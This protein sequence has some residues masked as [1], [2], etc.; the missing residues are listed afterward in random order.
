MADVRYT[1]GYAKLT[2]EVVVLERI[3]SYGVSTRGPVHLTADQRCCYI[4]TSDLLRWGTGDLV[5]GE[6]S[7]ILDVVLTWLVTQAMHQVH[8]VQVWHQGTVW[9]RL[10]RYDRGEWHTWYRQQTEQK[11]EELWRKV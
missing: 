7:L 5:P 6:T 8:T 11:E 9:G 2:P 4:F 3:P 10:Q 1:I